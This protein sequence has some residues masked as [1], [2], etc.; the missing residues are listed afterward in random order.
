M[1]QSWNPF[2]E[3]GISGF[4]RDGDARHTVVFLHGIGGRAGT[5]RPVVQAMRTAC[6][7]VSWDAPGYG[8]ST[9]LE[10]SWPLAA[11]YAVRLD[12]LRAALGAAS[13][14]IVGHSLG[15]LIAGA[16]AVRY[17]DRVRKLV[18]MAPALGYATRQ[19]DVS[20]I[21][22]A[23]AARIADV[24]RDGAVQFA[25]RRAGNLVSA[26]ASDPVR[27]FVRESMAT[28]DPA[29]YEQA[30]RMLASGDLMA[31]AGCF[32][33]ETLVINGSVDA[34]TP[35][36]GARR[37]HAA[38]FKRPGRTALLEIVM[39]AAH[40]VSIEQPADVARLID[41]FLGAT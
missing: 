30:A 20:A 32:A 26:T 36:E 25:A 6:R 19:G 28:I 34:V 11:D 38:L 10:T 37:L 29:G 17:P 23:I 9:P 8:T 39:G 41:S 35:P 40:A 21:P 24:A 18:L 12:V 4:I 1:T 14:D 7:V 13:V 22:A 3:A 27:D 16:Y 5:F 15:C 31:D 2:F 33:A